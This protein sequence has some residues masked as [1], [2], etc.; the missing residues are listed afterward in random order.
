MILYSLIQ[1][2]TSI[3]KKA[4]P[5]KLQNHISAESRSN[6]S[7]L[8]FHLR[9]SLTLSL[10]LVQSFVFVSQFFDSNSVEKKADRAV[11]DEFLSSC[12]IDERQW[13]MRPNT[14]DRDHIAQRARK[15]S[16]ISDEPRSLCPSLISLKRNNPPFSETD[17]YSR[18]EI[19]V[20]AAEKNLQTQRHS[21]A[22]FELK[23]AIAPLTDGHKVFAIC[24]LLVKRSKSHGHWNRLAERG[25]LRILFTSSNTLWFPASCTSISMNH[26]K[27]LL[28]RIVPKNASERSWMVSTRA[29]SDVIGVFVRKRILHSSKRIINVIL[30]VQFDPS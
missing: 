21:R 16:K 11:E 30:I 9:L 5:S 10:T 26:L 17:N 15:N 6:S 22:R 28:T 12:P 18:S 13:L 4:Y 25:R 14:V 29:S 23:K 2:P 7:S 3:T 1:Y 20:H 8:T 27:S 19:S 24:C